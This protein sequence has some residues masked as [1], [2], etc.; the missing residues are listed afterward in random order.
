MLLPLPQTILLTVTPSVYDIDILYANQ[1]GGACDIT[2]GIGDNLLTLDPDTPT[3]DLNTIFNGIL[4]IQEAGGVTV[5]KRAGL[6]DDGYNRVLLRFIFMSSS[7]NPEEET[8][9]ISV[10][11]N[12]DKC[13]NIT[14]RFTQLQTTP[15][16]QLGFPDSTRQTRPLPVTEV[17]AEEL[18]TGLETLLSYECTKTSPPNVSWT[19]YLTTAQLTVVFLSYLLSCLNLLFP[20]PSH[21]F[22]RL[23]FEISLSYLCICVSLFCFSHVSTSFLSYL[24]VS[25]LHFSHTYLGLNLPLSNIIVCNSRC[26]SLTLQLLVETGYEEESEGGGVVRTRAYCGRQSRQSPS[27]IWEGN[28]YR[29]NLYSHV[30]LT[31]RDGFLLLLARQHTH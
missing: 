20:F 25:Q 4:A 26:H 8:L 5:E 24:F 22:V 13:T 7:E 6:T 15:T 11:S 30:S 10:I 31:D 23:N 16:F 1:E 2:I 28:S 12:P 9:T 3:S 27:V 29:T 19:I 14:S 18:Q 21:L 17:T